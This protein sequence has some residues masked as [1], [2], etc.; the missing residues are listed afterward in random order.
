MPRMRLTNVCA[1]CSAGDSI[2]FHRRSSLASDHVDRA[3]V[4]DRGMGLLR[5]LRLRDIRCTWLFDLGAE[6]QEVLYSPLSA[7]RPV[8]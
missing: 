6:I 5:R 7:C 1:E 8:F 4:D 3:A 2:R